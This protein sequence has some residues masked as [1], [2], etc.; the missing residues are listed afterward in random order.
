MRG[1]DRRVDDCDQHAIAFRERMRL[2]EM[3][4]GKRVLRRIG[5]GR[6]GALLH[7]IEI[8]RLG[9]ENAR[10]RLQRADHDRDRP[11][12]IYAPPGGGG[13]GGGGG[14]PGGGGGGG[15]F[16]VVVNSGGR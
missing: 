12:G 4:L 16:F 10:I 13:G 2:R 7:R 14:L 9:A 1:I 8:V 6:R 5:G 11:A 3:Q 15:N